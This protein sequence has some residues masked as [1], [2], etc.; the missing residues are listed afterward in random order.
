MCT[1][2]GAELAVRIT[3]AALDSWAVVDAEAGFAATVNAAIT[4]VTPARTPQAA[5]AERQTNHCFSF[6][7][8]PL[9]P[10]DRLGRDI[11]DRNSDTAG[12]QRSL[13]A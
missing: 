3:G 5:A 2:D 7:S 6:N 13:P 10:S 12:D 1:I 9:P 8:V 4:T 11:A